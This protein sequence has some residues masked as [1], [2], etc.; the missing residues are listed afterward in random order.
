MVKL[1]SNGLFVLGFCRLFFSL[2]RRKHGGE[3]HNK[4]HG[5]DVQFGHTGRLLML[6][7]LFR[8][9]NMSTCSRVNRVRSLFTVKFAAEK[10]HFLVPDRGNVSRRG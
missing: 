8:K 6:P 5:S 10:K 7:F 9:I 1:E 2:P 3:K 4:P